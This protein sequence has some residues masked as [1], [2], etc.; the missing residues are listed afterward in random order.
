[1]LEA[2]VRRDGEVE[3]VPALFVPDG[4]GEASTRLGDLRGVDRVMVTAEPPG[5]S[6]APTSAPIASVA[7]PQ[8]R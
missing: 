7:I 5:G 2:W 1:V 6:K 4:E 8:V 3:A